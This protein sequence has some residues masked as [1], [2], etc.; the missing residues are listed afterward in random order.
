MITEMNK[1]T[2]NASGSLTFGGVG[3]HDGAAPWDSLLQFMAI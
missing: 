3:K 1:P 2:G